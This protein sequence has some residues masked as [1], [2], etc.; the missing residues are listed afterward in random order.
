MTVLAAEATS[1]TNPSPPLRLVLRPAPRAPQLARRTLRAACGAAGLSPHL[2]DDA[3]QVVGELVTQSIRQAHSL[4]E[5]VV[6]IGPEGVTVRVADTARTQPLGPHAPRGV[7][8]SWNVVRRLSAASGCRCDVRGR[9][10]WAQLRPWGR[11]AGMNRRPE[12]DARPI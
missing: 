3:A 1:A 12:S 5:V 8:R 10:M 6:E 2:V 7:V 4:V 9:E 11:R